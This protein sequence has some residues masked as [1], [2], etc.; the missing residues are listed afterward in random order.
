MSISDH[1]HRYTTQKRREEQQKKVLDNRLLEFHNRDDSMKEREERDH[2]RKVQSML[3][4]AWQNSIAEHKR[5]AAREKERDAVIQN[6]VLAAERAAAEAAQLRE[7]ERKRDA[8]LRSRALR[9]QSV[10]LE[11]QRREALC[12]ERRAGLKAQPS[13]LPI[14]RQVDELR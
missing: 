2:Q 12:K 13:P 6:S 5:I 7:A 11:Q 14:E 9:E 8:L 10:I 3:S 1:V 4:A